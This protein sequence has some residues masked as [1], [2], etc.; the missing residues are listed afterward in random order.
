MPIPLITYETI[1]ALYGKAFASTWF[2][3]ISLTTKAR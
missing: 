1:I 3:P 2:S